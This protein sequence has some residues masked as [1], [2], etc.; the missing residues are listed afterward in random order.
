MAQSEAEKSPNIPF[1]TGD[2]SASLRAT[3][4]ISNRIPKYETPSVFSI[5]CQTIPTEIFQTIRTKTEFGHSSIRTHRFQS[6][7][8]A[9]ASYI[10]VK[11]IFT[12]F[13]DVKRDFFICL[14]YIVYTLL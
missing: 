6:G 10:V 8:I 3:N 14:F 4:K 7:C 1:Y 12:T 2:P 9:V 13:C 5:C 11:K